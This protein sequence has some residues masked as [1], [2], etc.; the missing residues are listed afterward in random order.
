MSAT[1]APV[2]ILISGRGSNMQAIIDETQAGRLPIRIATV[3]SNKPEAAGLERARAA[4]I[5]TQV[6]DHRNFPSRAAFEQALMAAIDAHAPSLV[7]LAGF[8]RI[9]GREFIDHYQGRMIN[10]HP[11][12]LPAFPGLGTHARALQS[13][14]TRHGATVHFVT[15]EVDGGPIIAQAVVP[16]LPD[17]TVE[18]LGARVLEEEHRLY[19]RAIQWFVEGRVHLNDNQVM[20]DA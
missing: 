6:V 11:S 15:H 4:G 17:D 10:I 19:P 8:M 20:V 16:V 14:A 12:L 3:I 2:V 13:G 5:K 1:P 18:S 9:L 7:V